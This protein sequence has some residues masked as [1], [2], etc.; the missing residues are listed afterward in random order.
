MT[1]TLAA[2]Q[3]YLSDVAEVMKNLSADDVN[4]AVEILLDAYE[5]GKVVYT[6]GNGGHGSTA[7]HFANDITKHTMVS[8]N[9]DKIEVTGKRT[10]ALCMCDN[11]FK[12]TEW[13]NDMGFENAFV[14]P[15]SGWLKEGDVVVGIS[16]SGNSEN[17]LKSFRLAKERGAKSICFSG[18]KGGKAA[19]EADLCIIV[20][21]DKMLF[22]ED[23]HMV[24][25]HCI[26]DAMRS[27][28]R[29]RQGRA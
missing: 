11:P 18:F 26:A 4:K 23:V 29:E 19:T 3:Q 13:A 14:E 25:S 1:D 12:I 20:P 7:S 6:M 22:V 17:V 27:E 28:I 15:L 10:Q 9:K 24:M 21:S 2:V 16:G 5:N 8:D